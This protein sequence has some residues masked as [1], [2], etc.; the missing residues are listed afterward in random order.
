MASKRRW[1]VEREML[2][3]RASIA[4]EVALARS[5]EYN[6]AH[7]QDKAQKF[8]IIDEISIENVI[9]KWPG[10]YLVL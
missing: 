10:R 5:L 4:G 7:P 2:H 8:V 1:Q 6:I 9:I 3:R